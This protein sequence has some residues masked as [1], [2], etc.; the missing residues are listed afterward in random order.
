MGDGICSTACRPRMTWVGACGWVA[1]WPGF[2]RHAESE[3]TPLPREYMVCWRTANFSDACLAPSR[4]HCE[5]VLV[6]AIG[7]SL[8]VQCN[9]APARLGP[10]RW[11]R[12]ACRVLRCQALA[13]GLAHLRMQCTDPRMSRLLASVLHSVLWT[14]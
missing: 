8:C 3:Q 4:A 12:Q 1:F 9:D 13:S 2:L 7:V 10:N 6:V 14:Y 5:A 11:G